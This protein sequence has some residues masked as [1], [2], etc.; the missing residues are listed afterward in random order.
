MNGATLIEPAL[1]ISLPGGVPVTF[2]RIEPGEFL[3]GQRGEDAEEEPVHCVR[4]TQAFY[5]GTFPVTQ[6]QFAA[7]TR[8]AK[9]EHSNEFEERAEHPAVNIDWFQAADF[10]LWLVRSGQLPEDWM[11]CL[12]TEAEWEYACR[13]G[14]DSEYY[15]GEGEAVLREAGWFNRNSN[16]VTH[17]VGQK[18]PNEWGIFDM[19]G[20]VREWCR[21]VWDEHAYC[22][23]MD[24]VCDP[25][26]S[27]HDGDYSAN[28][29][30]ILRGGSWGSGSW[31][32]RSASR[33]SSRANFRSGYNGFRVALVPDW[34]AIEI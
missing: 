24:G 11:A 4:I 5:L 34:M 29:D 25:V 15:T 16:R 12:P 32:C 19:H 30:R 18:E 14:T 28:P 9:I 8:T 22:S 7:W 10:C 6:Q 23:R 13:A 33:L 17:P 20:N 31:T 27:I 2:Q 21:D 3:M 26:K 1:T